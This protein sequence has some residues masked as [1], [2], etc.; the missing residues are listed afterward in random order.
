MKKIILGFIAITIFGCSSDNDNSNTPIPETSLKLINKIETNLITNKTETINFTYEKGILVKS[1]EIESN[2]STF[3]TEFVYEN[4]KLKTQNYF[5]NLIPDGTNTFTYTGNVVSS[6]LSS[7]DNMYFLHKYTYNS[8]NQLINAKQFR[9]DK[10][11]DN[12][13]FEYN[14]QGNMSK[15][16]YTSN[17]IIST[18]EYDNKKNPYLLLFSE[19]I[20]N[21]NDEAGFSKNNITKEA[22][23]SGGITTYEYTYNDKGYPTQVIEK[24]NGTSKSKT[25]FTYE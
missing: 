11:E 6:S 7:E 15:I 14:S 12:K 24:Y 1:E 5:E 19:A 17:N 9:D 21:S 25:I 4:G 23:S 16:I 2:G 22:G 13:D 10:L 3:K 8:S 20:L 18:I